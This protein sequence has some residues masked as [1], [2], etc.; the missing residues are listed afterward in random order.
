[1]EEVAF[2]YGSK[3][4]GGGE[5]RGDELV[6]SPAVFL[7]VLD[8]VQGL[9]CLGVP[10]MIEQSVCDDSQED[11]GRSE[12]TESWLVDESIECCVR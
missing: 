9:V 1:V 5:E 3:S 4:I 8:P 11:A 6:K 12:K 7:G 2:S 10:T